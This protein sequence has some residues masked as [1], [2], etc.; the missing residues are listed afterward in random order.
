MILTEN[1]VFRVDCDQITTATFAILLRLHCYYCED[2]RPA[3]AKLVMYV[4][5]N[6]FKIVVCAH[7]GILIAC[8]V[9]L[10]TGLISISCNEVS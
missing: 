9:I 4:N 5:Y 7:L 8:D 3:A 6:H 2:I 1:K 10:S